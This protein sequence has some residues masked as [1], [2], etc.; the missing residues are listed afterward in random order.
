ML[1]WLWSSLSQICCGQVC[2][3]GSTCLGWHCAREWNCSE[4]AETC[5]RN[6]CVSGSS[7]AGRFCLG[8]SH[9]KLDESCCCGKCKSGYG[10][11]GQPCWEKDDC[12]HS[13]FC[14][15]TCTSVHC[16]VTSAIV[17][18]SVF[19]TPLVILVI[20]LTVYFTYQHYRRADGA[21][22]DGQREITEITVTETKPVYLGRSLPSYQEDDP[23]YP[24]PS[25]TGVYGVST[26]QCWILWTTA[27]LQFL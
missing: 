26:M 3:N 5:C 17:I 24:P 15:D 21:G 23:Y 19:G 14:G 27:S 6:A 9:S 18:G 16:S 22:I 2:I 1:C 10:C 8:R 12:G 4:G 20:Y 25:P 7:C 13:N 11:I